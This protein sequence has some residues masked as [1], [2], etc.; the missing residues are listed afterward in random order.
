[1]LEV[2]I[3][4]TVQR[5]FMPQPSET[6]PLEDGILRFC[7]S[8]PGTYQDTYGMISCLECPEG[9]YCTSNTSA[10]MACPAYSYCPNGTA[11]PILCLNG[12]YTDSATTGLAKADD[13][14]H[15]PSGPLCCWCSLCQL[16]NP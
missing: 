13:C 16:M 2:H 14:P 5:L 10:P 8:C 1:M 4:I 3:K 11:D 6:T 12:T 15:C 7:L 9:S